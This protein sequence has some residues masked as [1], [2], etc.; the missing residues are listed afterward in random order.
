[1]EREKQ[2]R[3]R[4]E[5]IGERKE[6]WV[7]IKPKSI[8]LLPVLYPLNLFSLT[9]SLSTFGGVGWRKE[10]K[11][12]SKNKDGKEENDERKVQKPLCVYACEGGVGNVRKCGG[13]RKDE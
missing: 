4:K 13:H 1:M 10:G 7:R 3:G 6:E 9:L 8:I 11:S 2:V 12:K 5:R